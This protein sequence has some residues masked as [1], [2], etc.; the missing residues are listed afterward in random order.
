MSDSKKASGPVKPLGDIRDSV[1]RRLGALGEDTSSMPDELREIFDDLVLYHETL[2]MR[3]QT[4]QGALVNLVDDM[5]QASDTLVETGT[6]LD[7][8][9]EAA[10][11][12]AFII[13]SSDSVGEIIEFSAGA[14]NMF[15]YSRTEIMGQPISRLCNSDEGSCSLAEHASTRMVMVRQSGEAFPALYSSYPLKGKHGVTSGTLVIVLDISK[16]EMAEKLIRESHERYMALALASPISIVT[17]D[18]EGIINFVNDWHMRMLDKGRTQPEYYIGKKI[19]EIPGI[20]RAGI[21]HRIMQVLDGS[22][23]SLEDVYIPPFGGREEAWNNIRLSPLTQDG[24]FTGGILIREDVTRRKRTELDLKLLIDSSPIPLLKVELGEGGGIIRSLN[25]EASTMLGQS[26]LNKPVD[27]YIT[28]LTEDDAELA[29]MQGE[30]C[31]VRTAK[32][33]RQGIRTSH[34]PSGQFEIQAVMDVTVLIQAKELAEDASR[35]KSDF[36]ANISHEIRTP[37]NV[38]LGML[39]LFEEEDLGEDINEMVGHA[40]GA[41]NSLLALLND[42]L[43]FSVVEARALALD[44]QEFSLSEIIELIATPY[45]IEAA[46]KDVVLSYA[47]DPAM[48]P[49][50]WGDARR[51]RQVLFH[52]TGNAVKF[53]DSGRILLEATWRPAGEGDVD[54]GII[55]VLVSDTG[56]GMT[57]GQM[58]HIFEPFRQ[59]DGARNRRHGGTGIG[60]ALVYEFVTAMGG[61]ITVDS[62]PGRGTQ[63]RFTVDVAIS[64]NV[65]LISE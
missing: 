9:L 63:F 17:F 19:S 55:E 8:I 40:M 29:G 44:E 4:M 57:D 41:A 48:P 60:L 2:D 38:L 5:S 1:R 11:D 30:R 25:P 47:I 35:A 46:G 53:T 31:E 12:V 45:R 3:E 15:G 62:R 32:G 16:R 21:G 52:V 10:E 42:I 65:P 28:V 14:Q 49:R 54:R 36:I 59:A 24:V 34:Q 33:L 18:A 20:I 43:D 13:A 64:K 37:L 39:Q 51:L 7:A 50:L 61:V 6:R 26:A 23:V 58:E 56:I 22:P 27:D